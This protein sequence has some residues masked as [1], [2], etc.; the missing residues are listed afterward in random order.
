MPLLIPRPYASPVAKIV[1]L[2]DE[3][4]EE[5]IRALAAAPISRDARDAT[6]SIAQAVPSI[7]LEDLGSIVDALYALYRVMEFSDSQMPVFLSDLVEGIRRISPSDIAGA[8]LDD[9][10]GLRQRFERLLSIGRLKALSKAFRLQREGER[11][12]CG[13][14]ILSDI[15]PVFEGDGSTRPDHA[16]ITHTLKIEYH[17]GEEH[18]EFL[19]VLDNEDLVALRGVIERATLKDATLRKLLK[20]SNLQDL[21]L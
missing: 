17:E 16:V 2:S 9:F 12:Y 19:V 7:P 8:K 5:L 20:E 13:A 18:R 15:R 14:K 11:L 3:A 4:V 1:K 21:G 10:G 6:A